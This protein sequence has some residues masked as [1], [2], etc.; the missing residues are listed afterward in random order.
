MTN[1]ASEKRSEPVVKKASEPADNLPAHELISSRFVEKHSTPARRLDVE[2]AKVNE[3]SSTLHFAGNVTEAQRNAKIVRA[4]ELYESLAPA[5]GVEG[6]L[7]TQMV[8]TH[9]AAMEWLRV[10]AHP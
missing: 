7:A 9:A 1:E 3:I 8:A 2:Y 5:D 4:L 6:M 10:A